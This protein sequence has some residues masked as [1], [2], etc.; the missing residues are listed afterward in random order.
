MTRHSHWCLAITGWFMIFLIGMIGCGQKRIHVATTSGSPDSSLTLAANQAKNDQSD[1]R[2]LSRSELQ[3]SEI[4]E[5]PAGPAEAAEHE[6]LLFAHQPASL[7]S[8]TPVDVSAA[9]TQ[10]LKATHPNSTRSGQEN[11]PTDT[12]VPGREILSQSPSSSG[13]TPDPSAEPNRADS[14]SNAN[15]DPFHREENAAED[16]SRPGSEPPGSRSSEVPQANQIASALA[17]PDREGVPRDDQ[18]LDN[19]QRAAASSHPNS[20]RSFPSTPSDRIASSPS[21]NR[22]QDRASA[23]LGSASEPNESDV[24]PPEPLALDARGASET[25]VSPE[26]LPSETT[27]AKVEPSEAIQHQLDQLKE[28]ESDAL[29][30]VFFEFDSWALTPEGRAALENNAEWLK[31][32]SSAKLLI[33]GH[34]DQRGTQAYNLVLGEKR[35]TAIRDYLI[36][37]GIDPDRLS[38]VSYGKEKPFC[39]D[40]TEVCYQLNRRGHFVVRNP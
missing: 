25:L 37:L 2:G 1:S 6:P 16:M 5:G 15:A 32:Q 11:E 20:V 33:Q 4:G 22:D 36:E 21:P 23:F 19:R 40:S 27:I 35:A 34:C 31:T 10:I 39:T 8:E 14:S 12:S 9:N 24:L 3:D 13:S 38:I 26:P 17:S 7:P 18:R 30:D 28:E 29:L